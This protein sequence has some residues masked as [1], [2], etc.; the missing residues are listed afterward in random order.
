M[1]KYRLVALIGK[2]G[3]GKDTIKNKLLSQCKGLSRVVTSTTR[4]AREGEVDGVDYNFLTDQEFTDKILN[5]DLIEATQH[6]E[7]FYGTDSV[8]L[9][10]ETINLI[11][12]TPDGIRAIQEAEDIDLLVIYIMCPNKE[13]LIRTLNRETA[14]DIDEIFRRYKQDREDFSDLEFNFTVMDNSGKYSMEQIV[15][16]CRDTI[17]DYFG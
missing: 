6:R 10:E 2:S 14:P 8:S 11:V 7:W 12:L 15:D 1:S 9:K 3:S 4:P 17:V 5:G 13:R 16:S